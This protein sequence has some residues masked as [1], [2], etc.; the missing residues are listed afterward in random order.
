MPIAGQSFLRCSGGYLALFAAFQNIYL[1]CPQLPAKPLRT[2]CETLC[3][4]RRNEITRLSR[5]DCLH[6]SA[7]YSILP[8]NS[9][10]LLHWRKRKIQHFCFLC[11][12][13]F[14]KKLYLPETNKHLIYI[15]C[16][17]PSY[18]KLLHA[19]W[20]K[21]KW[22][23][24]LWTRWVSFESNKQTSVNPWNLSWWFDIKQF[25]HSV[26]IS[27][28]LHRRISCAFDNIWLRKC[29]C[30]FWSHPCSPG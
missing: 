17:P 19:Q 25:N 22:S 10:W 26:S 5:T 30:C 1:C 11:N 24:Y 21:Q 16:G 12:S 13:H 29:S 14:Y 28:D 23:Q 7:T 6:V 15:L 2:F 9:Q 20:R 27:E 18:L 4:L 3:G 8:R